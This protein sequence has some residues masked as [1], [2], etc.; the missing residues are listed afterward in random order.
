MLDAAALGEELTSYFRGLIAAVD[1]TAQQIT[2]HATIVAR[3]EPAGAAFTLTAH[4][5]D[6]FGAG[7]P[8]DLTGWAR[9]TPCGSGALWVFSFA[10]PTSTSRAEVD[11]L[12]LAATCR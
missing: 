11:A 1:A 12:A 4:V 10:P 7:N 3:A 6:A 8:V 9:R 2:D 5:F